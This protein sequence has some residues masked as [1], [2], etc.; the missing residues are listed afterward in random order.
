MFRFLHITYVS[1]VI[2]DQLDLVFALQLFATFPDLRL[3]LFNTGGWLHHVNSRKDGGIFKIL[4]ALPKY[5]LLHEL[6]GWLSHISKLIYY[7]ILLVNNPPLPPINWELSLREVILLQELM[8]QVS[9][10]P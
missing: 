6:V 9:Y 3:Y 1:P 5:F 10:H 7:F 8:A 4:Y 2:S